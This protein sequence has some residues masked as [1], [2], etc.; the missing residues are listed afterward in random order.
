[1]AKLVKRTPE[2]ERKIL[3]DFAFVFFQSKSL[4]ALKV[5]KKNL[6][7]ERLSKELSYPNWNTLSGMA[8]G[9]TLKGKQEISNGQ[10]I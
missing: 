8:K 3:V 9:V 7:L 4:H 2:E 1:M 10:E 6:S 5:E